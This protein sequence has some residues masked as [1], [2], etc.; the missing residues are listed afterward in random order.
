MPLF[1][2]ILVAADLSESS[3]ESFRVACSLARE[4]ETR[5]VVLSV[6]E[7]MYVAPEPV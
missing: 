3:R 4:G 5:V 1:R 2:T 6:A 7:P